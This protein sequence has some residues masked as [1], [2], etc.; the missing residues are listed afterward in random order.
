MGKQG[1]ANDSL[2]KGCQWF[3]CFSVEGTLHE[4]T[5]FFSLFFFVYLIYYTTFFD[6]SFKFCVSLSHPTL[7]LI[8]TLSSRVTVQLY[9]RL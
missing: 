9:T 1:G 2:N 6:A 4:V 8:S 5:P 7:K 3:V